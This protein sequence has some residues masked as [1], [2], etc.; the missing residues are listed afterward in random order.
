MAGGKVLI[1]GTAYDITK[2]KTMIGGTAYDITAGKT[3]VGGTAY[4]IKFNASSDDNPFLTFQSSSDFTIQTTTGTSSEWDGL[5]EYSTD[6]LT[7]NLWTGSS[8][9]SVNHVLYLRGEENSHL[10]HADDATGRWVVSGNNISIYGNVE[11][12]F[13]YDEVSRGNHPMTAG[14]ALGY[15]FWVDDGIVPIIRAPSFFVTS[16]PNASLVGAFAKCNLINEIDLRTVETIQT[17]SLYSFSSAHTYFSTNLISIA[18]N[19]F[20]EPTAGT[21]ST[22]T[23]NL[24]Y[25]FTD[26]DAPSFTVSN[27]IPAGSSKGTVT[28]NIYTDNTSIKNAA[29]A[30][31][32]EYTIV[33]V[34]HLNGGEW[35]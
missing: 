27:A 1:G 7:W 10:S 20:V 12:V 32:D 11:T 16:L 19:A 3:L 29:L 13:D 31:I 2:G 8:I 28:S 22:F 21:V 26:N 23:Y 33:N 6:T 4:D 24:H 5:I 17:A 34:Y 14:G 35:T 25:E 15:W 9:S 30:K 18:D